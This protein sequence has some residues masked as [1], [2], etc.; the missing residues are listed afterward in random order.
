LADWSSS[1]LGI[2][3]L[4]VLTAASGV[5]LL[6][7]FLTP[8]SCALTAAGTVFLRIQPPTPILFDAKLSTLFVVIMAT[9]IGFLGPGAFSVDSR[10]FGRR[11]IIIPPRSG[12][13]K[14]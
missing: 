3:V 10:L 11:E 7:G 9:A 13:P 1:T 12:L 6:I 8:V 2:W 5:S 4:G 14:A